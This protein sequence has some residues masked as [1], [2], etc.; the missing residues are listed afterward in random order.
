MKWVLITLFWVINHLFPVTFAQSCTVIG[1]TCLEGPSQ[2]RINGYIVTRD[3]WQWQE[4]KVCSTGQSLDHCT[5]LASNP[6]CTL[7]S[8]SCLSLNASGV[9][10]HSERTFACEKAVSNLPADNTPSP[11]VS[12]INK[13]LVRPA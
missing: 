10:S 3:C 2:K 13:P 6:A 12:L 11:F 4:E 8:E 1:Q 5:T 9:C 7:E